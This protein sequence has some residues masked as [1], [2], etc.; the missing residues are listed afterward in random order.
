MQAQNL[1]AIF[2]DKVQFELSI[3]SEQTA[4]QN[5]YSFIDLIFDM[6]ISV[7]EQSIQWQMKQSKTKVKKVRK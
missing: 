6:K 7:P 3:S 5:I 4:N 2:W 1:F